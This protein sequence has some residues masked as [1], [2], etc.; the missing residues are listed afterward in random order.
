MKLKNLQFR[1]VH[2]ALFGVFAPLAIIIS[3][4]PAKAFNNTLSDWQATYPASMADENAAASGSA[5]SLCHVPNNFSQWNGY[6]WE[7]KQNGRDFAAAEFLNSDGDPTGAS[8]LEE[9]ISNTQPGWTPGANNLIN[10][11]NTASSALPPSGIVGS[12]DPLMANQPPAANSGG[13][14]NGT[15]GI[16]VTLDGSGSTDSDGTIV[17]YEWDFGDGNIDFGATPTHTYI[18]TGLFTITLTVTDDAGDTNTATTTATIAMGNQP[19]IANPNGPYTGTAGTP[20]PLSGS[21]SI[22]PDGTIVA[23]DWDFGDGAIGTGIAP[24]YAYYIPG[25]YNITLTVRDDS[26]AIG[27]ANTTAAIDAANQPPTA[28]PSGP[29]SGMVNTTVAFDG[30][31]STDLDGTISSYAWDFGDG[32]TGTGST[33]THTYVAESTYNVALTVTDDGGLTD[34]AMTTAAIGTT[35]NQPPVANANGPYAGTVGLPVTFDSTGSDDPDGTLVA[36][37]WSFGD[38][39]TDTG[40]NPTHAYAMPG[41]YNVSLMVTDDAGTIDSSATTATIGT[42]NQA[43]IANANGPYNGTAGTPVQLYSIGSS[44][45]DG[46]ITAY[47]WDFGDGTTGTGPSPTHAYATAGTYN[48]TLT[49]IDDNNAGDSNAT[50]ATISEARTGA[51]VFL[52]KLWVP[53]SIK[54]KTGKRQSKEIVALGGGTSIHQGA[55]VNLRVTTPTTGLNVVARRVSITEVVEPG[56]DPEQFEFRTKITCLEEG[57]YTLGWSATISAAQNSDFSNDTL[58]GETSVL[59]ARSRSHED[60]NKDEDDKN[61]DTDKGRDNEDANK[62]EDGDDENEDRNEDGDDGDEGMDKD[63]DDD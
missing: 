60:E 59:C 45:P 8:N 3:A 43:P 57:T 23:Y 26:G 62:D 1:P 58:T 38:G 35:T 22:D 49:V 6:G 17:A 37:E 10:G 34:T 31:G 16:P 40:A 29:Y 7:L 25:T 12:L 2:A 39:T 55:T 19:P 41:T 4:T 13:P 27:S 52:T 14:Y 51:D 50:T 11:G 28:N 5:C 24:N 47:N 15:E 32:S 53:E 20:L 18:S 42:G 36:Y 9:I 63:G 54:L 61:E 44:D 56:E 33:P 30:T 48:I 46:T 21:G